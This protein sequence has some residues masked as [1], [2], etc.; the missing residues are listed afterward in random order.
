MQAE[1]KGFTRP[2]TTPRGEFTG[3]RLLRLALVAVAYDHARTLTATQPRSLVHQLLHD[4]HHY[5]APA[6]IGPLIHHARQQGMLTHANHGK[7]GGKATKRA[8]ILVKQAGIELPWE[9]KR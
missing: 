6:S 7:A 4:L 8:R 9:T 2:A 1:F 5:Y 3:D